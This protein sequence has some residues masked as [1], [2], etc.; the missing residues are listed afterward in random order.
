MSLRAVV[1]TTAYRD[2]V[3]DASLRVFCRH[4]RIAGVWAIK[5]CQ[6][7]CQLHP[8]ARHMQYELPVSCENHA[9][10]GSHR[11]HTKGSL[12]ICFQ[13]LSDGDR[14][15]AHFTTIAAKGIKR[16]TKCGGNHQRHQDFIR[17]PGTTWPANFG[18]WPIVCSI[19]R[20]PD[21]SRMSKLLAIG[22]AWSAGS[23]ELLPMLRQPRRAVMRR[24]AGATIRS[25]PNT[26]PGHTR[27]DMASTLCCA[28]AA[29]DFDASIRVRRHAHFD[30]PSE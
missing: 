24:L 29:K 15:H 7:M 5:R 21:G 18:C 10:A 23:Q 16:R 3:K 8:T 11:R 6:L 14:D 19:Q 20:S 17:C 30:V 22:G 25:E 13:R 27:P 4:T 2:D 9:A 26:L 28:R 12:S 1:H